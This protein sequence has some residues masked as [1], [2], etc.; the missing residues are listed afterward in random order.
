[1]DLN[2]SIEFNLSSSISPQLHNFMP[3]SC[4]LL[5][6]YHHSTEEGCEESRNSHFMQVLK[7]N[8][9]IFWNQQL[10]EIHNIPAFKS[11]H[12]LPLAR[13]KRIMKYDGEVKMISAETPLLFSKACEL[14][15][16]ELTL[17][18]WL[19]TEVCKRRTLQRCDIAR[20]IRTSHTLDFLAE[21]VPFDHHKDGETENCS[22]ELEPL[23][24]IQVPFPVIDINE[25]FVLTNH[26]IAQQFMMR[27]ST[28]PVEFNYEFDF[29]PLQKHNF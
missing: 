2:Q 15:I 22:D 7:Q 13:I 29:K 5:P 14:F 26:G 1:M 12:Q 27:T 9:A 21:V 19:Q 23:P 20:A 24:A 8:L 28:S 4:F 6:T 10:L 11:H 16:L 25:D 3:M 17:R 18:A